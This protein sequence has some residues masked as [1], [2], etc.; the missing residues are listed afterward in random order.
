APVLFVKKKDGSLRLCVDYRALNRLTIKNRYPL[1]LIPGL[2]D[3]VKG[4]TRFT[5]LDLPTAYHLLRIAMGDEWKTAFRTRYGHFE[6]LVMPFGLTNAPA[7][8][9][10]YIN[11][12]LRTYLDE[13]C[14]AYIDD[15]LIYSRTLEERIE[16]VRK[17]LK[18][19]L[20]HGLYVKLEKCQFHVQEIEFL[21]YVLSPEGV[22]ISKERIAMIVE[23]PVPASMHD[24][25][26]F[27]GFANFYRRFIEGYSR[28]VLPLT[29]LL[30]KNVKFKWTSEAQ[31]AFDNL[32]ALFTSAPLLKHFDPEL[33][34]TLH[35]DASGAAISG[36]LSQI[37]PNGDLHP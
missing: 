33:P 2:L 15:I 35:T 24:I 7:T 23:W 28:V 29:A 9:Q 36:I 16:H 27:L 1:P 12:V 6:Y 14:V 4:A 32:K 21:G 8:F 34:I 37:H 17:I 18:K 30:R 11:E 13:F 10:S 25:Q 22:S 3:H 20:E 5:R 19:L 31:A 26:V